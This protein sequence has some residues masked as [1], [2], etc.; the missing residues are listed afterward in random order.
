MSVMK[1]IRESDID[2]PKDSIMSQYNH[3]ITKL[4]E[5]SK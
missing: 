3:K 1:K 4:K 5:I 2:T